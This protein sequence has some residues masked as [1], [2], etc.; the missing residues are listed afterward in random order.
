MSWW[1]FP[2]TG[3]FHGPGGS[4]DFFLLWLRMRTSVRS[5]T[6]SDEIK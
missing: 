6:T 1:R 4:F 2:I 3:S 5:K